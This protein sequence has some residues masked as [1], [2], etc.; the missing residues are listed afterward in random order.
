MFINQKK[1]TVEE[2]RLYVEVQCSGGHTGE[3]ILMEWIKSS[4]KI[5]FYQH[6]SFAYRSSFWEVTNIHMNMSEKFEF[7]TLVTKESSINP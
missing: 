3:I 2:M 6:I 4:A 7:S 1:I 5:F